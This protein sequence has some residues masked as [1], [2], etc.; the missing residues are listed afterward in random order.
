MSHPSTESRRV[1]QRSTAHASLAALGVQLQRLEVF[2][3]IREQ[4]H[5]AQ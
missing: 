1:V 5:I 3:P 2:G 4:A